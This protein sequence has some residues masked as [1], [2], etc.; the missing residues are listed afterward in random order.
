MKKTTLLTVVLV[1]LLVV[2]AVQAVQLTSL[3]AKLESNELTT[4]SRTVKT[5]TQSS[6]SGGD[7]SIPDSLGNLPKMVG[8]C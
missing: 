2:S 1:V 6:G 8:G 7:I 5:S 4:K 3:K